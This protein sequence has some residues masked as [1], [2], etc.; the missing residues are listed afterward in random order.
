MANKSE[1]SDELK[2]TYWHFTSNTL[3]SSFFDVNEDKA[4]FLRT[5]WILFHLALK[6]KK[7]N[8]VNK[9]DMLDLL[10]LKEHAKT[11]F[12]QSVGTQ[13]KTKTNVISMMLKDHKVQEISTND[14]GQV[15]KR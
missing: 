7:A 4:S 6:K 2:K 11:R 1:I 15:N 8:Q 9:T 10:Q 5:Y 13:L 3:S 12:N 14:N